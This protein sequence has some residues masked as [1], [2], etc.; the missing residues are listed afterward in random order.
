MFCFVHYKM[1]LITVEQRF[2]TGKQLALESMSINLVRVRANSTFCY[3]ILIQG[4][5]SPPPQLLY[6]V[7]TVVFQYINKF[8]QYGY[9]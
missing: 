5:W 2:H 8:P 3:W 4:N 6:G 7:D 1:S 9:T